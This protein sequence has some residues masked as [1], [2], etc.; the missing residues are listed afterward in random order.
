MNRSIT[1]L[2]TLLCLL[3]L[4]TSHAQ[5][6]EQQFETDPVILNRISEWQ[7]LKF[8]FMMHW[9]IYAQWGIV[10]SWSICNEPWIDRNGEP[11]TDYKARYQALNKTFNP[12]NFNP[13]AWAQ[14]AKDAGMK[15]FVF[16]TKHHDGFCLFDTKETTYSTTDPSCPFSANPKADITKAVVDAFRAKGL[17]TGLYFSK[18]DWHNEDYWAPEW[19]TPDRNVNY[20]PEK[21]P[22]RWQK[23]CDFTDRQIQELMSNYGDIDLLWLDGGWVRPAWSV[24][25]EVRDWLGCQGWIQDI[26]MDK[27]ITKARSHN[28]DLIV[29]D[30]T[31]HG[32]YE[33]YRTPEQTVPDTLLPY[34][35]ETCMSMGDSWSYVA[36]DKYKS[37][38]KLIHLL[39]DIVAKGGNFLLNVGPGPDGT[40]PDTALARMKEIGA[41]MRVNGDAIYAT[42]PL[43]PYTCQD[44]RLTQT[45]QGKK[46]AIILCP[47][48]GMMASTYILT[49][50]KP[51]TAR[52]G[53]AI[54]KGFSEK[55]T[56][57][58][59]GD[60]TYKIVLPKSLC[61]KAKHAIVVEL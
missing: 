41:W 54:V 51:F 44:I 3:V 52:T 38:N 19:A 30:R 40:L 21:H 20:D 5:T 27:I 46:F 29:V 24:D 34:P 45:K 11:Y 50:D 36:T 39:V 53:K 61:K 16:T 55:A 35:W 42:R 23:F 13:D 25:E 18:A 57:S 6:K 49:S 26:N 37:T 60:N 43:Y 7:D 22:E 17:W 12:T 56:I 28:P 33:N 14:A 15:Y 9:G 58:K 32:R 1:F 8:G 31:V 10:E 2:F 4:Q 48:T 59:T 47:E